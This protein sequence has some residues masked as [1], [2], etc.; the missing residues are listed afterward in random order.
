M[1]THKID[2]SFLHT[3]LKSPAYIPKLPEDAE[4]RSDVRL[5]RDMKRRVIPFSNVV[6]QSGLSSKP[7]LGP[8]ER[9]PSS[10]L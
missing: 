7:P 10:V 4:A 8:G 2:I 3:P 6:T 1:S 5:R 9:Y